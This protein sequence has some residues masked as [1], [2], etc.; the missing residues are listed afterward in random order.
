M[1][2]LIILQGPPCSGKSTWARQEAAGKDDVVI[3]SKDEIRHSLGDYWIPRR[4]NLVADIERYMLKHSIQM[5]FTVICDGLNMSEDRIRLLKQ[6]A[7][8]ADVPMERK[9][10]Y[11]PFREAVR[12]DSNP[13]RRHN[14]GERAIRAF[15]EK[16]FPDRLADELSR[17]APPA[18]LQ[19][20]RLIVDAEG[21]TIWTPTPKDLDDVKKMASIRFRISQI[22]RAIAVPESELRRLLAVK[23]SPVA[24]AYEEGKILGEMKYKQTTQQAA[25]RGE[26]WAIRMVERWEME[27]RKEELGFQS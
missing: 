4:E 19:V 11:V 9:E 2:K 18:P 20:D 23:E 22:A 27:Q 13:D 15:Y 26:E 8:E 6:V 17:P 5:G 12:R 10:M 14:V 16:H 3:V 25:E 7:D 24:T 21:K 1:S